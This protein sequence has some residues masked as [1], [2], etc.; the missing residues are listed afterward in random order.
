MARWLT[1]LLLLLGVF[2]GLALLLQ[3]SARR[4]SFAD[5]GSTYRAAEDGARALYL[6]SEARGLPVERRH[7]DLGLI[8]HE[9]AIV[10][11]GVNAGESCESEEER[12]ARDESEESEAPARAAEEEDGDERAGEDEPRDVVVGPSPGLGI[13]GP[14]LSSEECAA[15]LDWVAEGGNLV[16]VTQEQDALLSRLE[17]SL[18]DRATPVEPAPEPEAEPAGSVDAPVD[19]GEGEERPPWEEWLEESDAERARREKRKKEEEQ[20]IAFL[21]RRLE[22]EGPLHRLVPGQPSVF[23]RGIEGVESTGEVRILTDRGDAVSVLVEAEVPPEGRARPVAAVAVP[24][25]SGWV[26]AVSVPELALN[27][28][29]PRAGNAAFWM[30]ALA[31]VTRNGSLAFDEYHHGHAAGRTILG[32]A[33]EH[34]LLPALLQL[35]LMTVVAVLAARRLGRIELLPGE[36]LRSTADHLATMANLY[37]LGGHRRHAARTIA[38]RALA[39]AERYR[40]LPAVEDAAGALEAQL[41]RIELSKPTERDLSAVA[42]AAAALYEIIRS[43]QQGTVPRRKRGKHAA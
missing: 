36:T 30:T 33:L 21:P 27:R 26:L 11:V 10:L 5:A 32:Y 25:G 29:L 34:G 43:K 42:A 3:Q 28:T 35:M 13:F 40:S 4:G 39:Q 19:Q 15:L 12:E 1:P 37:R 23:T 8:E 7:L 41:S 17:L 18:R 2:L 9:G 14:R 6:L 31:E 38:R 24:H 16:H 22:A 20:A